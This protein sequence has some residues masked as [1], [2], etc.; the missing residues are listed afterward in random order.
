MGKLEYKLH[1]G[2]IVFNF[3]K[4]NKKLIED[5]RTIFN[6]KEIDR[7]TLSEIK[8]NKIL[9]KHTNGS[10]E[11]AVYKHLLNQIIWFINKGYV[12]K[13]L[14]IQ[15]VDG[16]INLVIDSA[17]KMG[18]EKIV[19]VRIPLMNKNNTIIIKS[20]YLTSRII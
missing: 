9:E 12:K 14:K 4:L 11:R 19:R 16:N 8:W 5:L 15:A 20:I 6:N 18:Q 13:G 7:I 2:L 1:N 17:V 3:N 10:G